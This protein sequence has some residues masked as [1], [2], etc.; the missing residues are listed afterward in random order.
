MKHIITESNIFNNLNEEELIL[1]NPNNIEEYSLEIRNSQ[2]KSLFILSEM[3]PQSIIIKNCEIIE[4]FSDNKIPF[5]S[6][7]E[8]DYDLS[9]LFKSFIKRSSKKTF[10]IKKDSIITETS[11]FNLEIL[12]PCHLSMK[13]KVHTISIRSSSP[14]KGMLSCDNLILKGK[15]FSNI[16]TKAKKVIYCPTKEDINPKI[17]SKVELI[18][19]NIKMN[20]DSYENLITLHMKDI[21]QD[22]PE[23]IEDLNLLDIKK[24]NI[25]IE[26]LLN[27]RKFSIKNSKIN[28][29]FF[30]Y[31]PV[32]ERVEIK[33]SL[34][35]N[36][37]FPDDYFD[38]FIDELFL[39]NIKNQENINNIDTL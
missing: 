15:G 29:V 39:N 38:L 7:I 14:V 13:N 17:K 3:N 21:I 36:I 35:K 8:I 25:I 31:N 1:V 22:I 9:F 16:Y 28:S 2:I 6:E 4:N 23:H 18:G 30:G 26:H 37:N 34:V 11:S 27:L 10:F 12:K 5:E 24:G 32:L 20:L 19:T 33:K